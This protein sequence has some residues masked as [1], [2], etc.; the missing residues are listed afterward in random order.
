M[1]FFESR[2]GLR[3]SSALLGAAFLAVI[4]APANAA[5]ALVVD[6]ASGAVLY[7]EDA[8]RPWYPASLTKLMTVYVALKAVHERRLTMETPLVVSNRAARMAPSKMGFKPGA[9]VTLGNALKMIMVKSANDVS[10]TIAEGV[11]G[12]VES[13]A[14]EMNAVARA[15]GMRNS[16]FVNP[17]GLHDDANVSTAQDMAILAR[18]LLTHFP[19]QRALYGIGAL[20]LD[21]QIIQTHNGLLG[22]YPGA[23]GM[24]TGFIC[25]SGF[26]VVATATRGGRQLVAVVMGSP[27]AKARTLKTMA[28]FEHAF[29]RGASGRQAL[30]SLAAS[31]HAAPP[32]LRST[33][34]GPKRNRDATEDLSHLIAGLHAGPATGDDSAAS[35]FAADRG[36]ASSSPAL[37]AII[38]GDLGP[39]PTFEPIPV[40]LGRAP[41]Y[42]G[43]ARAAMTDEAPAPAA[44][45]PPARPAAAARTAKP[46]PAANAAKPA[47]RKAARPATKKP[48]TAARASATSSNKPIAK[49]TAKPAAKP[50]SRPASRPAPKAAQAPLPPRR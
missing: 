31:Q 49:P 30:T 33:I 23:D 8:T 48:A 32:N 41:G 46:R 42:A 37:Q 2:A 47:A 19:Q 25:A 40:Y 44:A 17:H 36:V 35:F 43:A 1:R 13:F 29:A 26:N 14:A 4:A 34:C 45:P 6:A 18:A 24:K 28:M 10:V 22:R 7:Q 5:P 9:E 50:A 15:L 21:A 38:S 16:N 12:S 11:S 39:R 27:N 20:R 3:V